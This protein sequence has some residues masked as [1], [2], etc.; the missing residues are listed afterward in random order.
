MSS[1]NNGLGY[2]HICNPTYGARRVQAPDMAEINR[3]CA[4]AD[5]LIADCDR[6]IEK[7]RKATA[8]RVASIRAGR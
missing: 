6:K 2:D 5:K 1:F 3:L 4:A 8:R 7:I